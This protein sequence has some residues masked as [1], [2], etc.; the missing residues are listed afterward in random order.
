MR[1]FKRALA[2]HIQLNAAHHHHH[3]L[4]LPPPFC[5]CLSLSNANPPGSFS[6][7]FWPHWAAYKSL[8]TNFAFSFAF[9]FTFLP[10]TKLP[11]F[12][13]TLPHLNVIFSPPSSNFSTSA[14]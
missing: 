2:K 7:P 13:K 4:L 8:S 6:S 14:P 10:S 3:H 1:A 9:P 5:T 12:H 11:F